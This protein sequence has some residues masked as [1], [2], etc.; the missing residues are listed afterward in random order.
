MYIMKVI[1]IVPQS[2][3]A[4]YSEYPDVSLHMKVCVFLMFFSPLVV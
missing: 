3:E 1:E 2:D 4:D